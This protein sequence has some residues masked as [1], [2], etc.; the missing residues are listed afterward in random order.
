MQYLPKGGKIALKLLN[1]I[2][3][4]KRLH[5]GTRFR[6]VPKS[7]TL[8][9]LERSLHTLFQNSASFEAHHEILMKI[10]AYYQSGAI[11]AK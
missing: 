7:T 4:N 1:V 2:V 10:N 5:T 9:D 11:T 8:D 6:L 3:T